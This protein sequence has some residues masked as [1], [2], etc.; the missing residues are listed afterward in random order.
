MSFWNSL[1][2]L[3]KINSFLIISWVVISAV[4]GLLSWEIQS[5]ITGLNISSEKELKGKV[6]I[7]ESKAKEFEEKLSASEQL[8]EEA[9]KRLEEQIKRTNSQVISTQQKL[10][11]RSFSKEQKLKL[12]EFLSTQPKGNNV[13]ITCILGDGESLLFA[14]EIDT[15]LKKIG[16]TTRGVSQ[17]VFTGSPQGIILVVKSEAEAPPYAL[18]LQQAFS[19]IGIQSLGEINNSLQEQE[20]KIIVGHKQN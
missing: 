17:A 15:I 11:P 7:T 5:R 2:F 20:L 4:F 10:S 14:K 8:R 12:E 18:S 6:E 13:D 9:E 16:W 1:E 3:H 19:I